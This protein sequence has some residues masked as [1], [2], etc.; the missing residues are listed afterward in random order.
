MWIQ[1]ANQ[2]LPH[3]QKSFTVD[4]EESFRGSENWLMRKKRNSQEQDRHSEEAERF[5]MNTRGPRWRHSVIR[6]KISISKWVFH[7]SLRCVC[8]FKYSFFYWLKNV[9]INLSPLSLCYVLH[10]EDMETKVFL[11]HWRLFKFTPFYLCWFVRFS[12][13]YVSWH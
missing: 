1:G 12:G 11:L 3:G 5:L 2:P 4:T 9:P 7:S 8:D 10:I 13:K 6:D